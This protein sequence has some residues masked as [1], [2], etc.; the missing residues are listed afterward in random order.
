[1]MDG[2]NIPDGAGTGIIC[3][4]CHQ[5]RESGLTVYMNIVSVGGDPYGTPDEVIREG[6]G[7]NF[8]NPHYL[9]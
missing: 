9:E 2:T 7:I 4:F 3:L 5:G 8:S 6:A 1:M